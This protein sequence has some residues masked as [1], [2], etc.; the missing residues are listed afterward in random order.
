MV[1]ASTVGLGAVLLQR[2]DGGFRPVEYASRSLSD[3]ERRYSQSLSRKRLLSFEDA[4][5]FISFF[6]A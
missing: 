3:V 4:D 6:L 2:H 1:D 5:V